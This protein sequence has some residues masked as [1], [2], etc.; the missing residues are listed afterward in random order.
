MASFT[1]LVLHYTFLFSLPISARAAAPRHDSD[2][3]GSYFNALRRFKYT[4]AKE[5]DKIMPPT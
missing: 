4:A 5:P 1:F 2:R 3:G